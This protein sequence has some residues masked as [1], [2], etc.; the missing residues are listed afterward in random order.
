MTNIQKQI[1]YRLAKDILEVVEEVGIA[2]SSSIFLALQDQGASLNQFNS[3]MGTLVDRGY[4]ILD[5]DAYTCT[6]KTL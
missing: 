4:L 2:P 5:N 6:G 3:I 1:V